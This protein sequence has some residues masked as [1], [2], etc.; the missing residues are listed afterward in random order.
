[1]KKKFNYILLLVFTILV[2]YFSLK[3][4]F[5]LVV[6]T[7]LTM[8]PLWLIIALIVMSL[9]WI[10]KALVTY[11]YVKKYNKDYT[12]KKA[13]R[14][15]METMFF[16]GIT[17]FSSGGQPF[18]VVSLKQ[19]G[20]RLSTGT[21]I[22]IVS[23]FLHQLVL[24]TIAS[25]AI[26]AN[27][28]LKL[29]PPN[30]TIRYFSIFGY[31]INILFMGFLL[32]IMFSK[33]FNKKSINIVIYLL[34]KIRIVKDKQKVIDSW[35]E[36]VENLSESSTLIRKDRKTFIMGYFYTLVA[37]L[38]FSIIPFIVARGMG[39][40]TFNIYQTLITI[41]YVEMVGM[42]IPI[43]GGTGGLEFAFT[44]LFGVFIVGSTVNSVMLV[45][46]FITY[47]LGI[48]L[49]GMVLNLKGRKK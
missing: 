3:D 43:P 48:I 31:F 29:F 5:G 16:N 36:R 8:N 20:V 44:S 41:A 21:N 9:Y 18:Q 28:F 14:L 42:F 35:N 17:P 39:I 6:D 7:I 23:S 49:G 47:Y 33:K 37:L 38:S 15:Q 27:Q 10:F 1:M 13:I 32:L 2:L 34:N 24:F 4:D 25:I 26:L 12:Y 11:K 46:R 22:I 19:D 30:N 45:W 40:N